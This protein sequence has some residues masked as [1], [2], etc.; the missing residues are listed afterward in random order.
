[1]KPPATTRSP[2]AHTDRSAPSGRLDPV[3]LPDTET[4]SLPRP[5]GMR[6]RQAGRNRPL[7][8]ANTLKDWIVERGLQPGARLP[9]EHELIAELGVAKSTAREAIK[10]LEAQ[11]LVRTR[12]GP[13]GGA[14]VTEVG[15][16]HA[17]A[18]LANHFFF[19]QP[20]IADIYELRIALEPLLVRELCAHITVEEIET[21]RRCMSAYTTRPST[22]EEEREQRVAELEFHRQLAMS[23]RN[24]LL[25]FTCGFLIRLLEDLAVCRRIYDRPNPE[26]RESGVSYQERLI[27]ALLA[28]DA[29]EASTVMQAHMRT[30]QRIMLAQEAQLTR[31]FL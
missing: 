18:L 28:R 8:V 16:D 23:S 14:F 4:R 5:M 29:E 25:R 22:I 13:G 21:L 17:T 24:P 19:E 7:A 2:E 27:A 11:G 1:M 6:A 30:A 10:L 3:A 26:L 20:S 15:A 12:T 31:R 9:Q